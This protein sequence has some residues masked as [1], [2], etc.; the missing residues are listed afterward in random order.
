MCLARKSEERT[1]AKTIVACWNISNIVSFQLGGIAFG[2][3]FIETLTGIVINIEELAPRV[4]SI[5]MVFLFINQLRVQL[6]QPQYDAKE[7]LLDCIRKG[8]LE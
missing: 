5:I 4:S 2:A 3:I 8:Q 1:R 7:I 6:Y